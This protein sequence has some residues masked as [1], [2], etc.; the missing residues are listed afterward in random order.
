MKFLDM[1]K[2][3]IS[4]RDVL[5]IV[6]LLSLFYG[7]FLFIPWVAYVVCGAVVFTLAFIFGGGE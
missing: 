7:L 2:R 3:L 1:A 6:G 5:L 4:L